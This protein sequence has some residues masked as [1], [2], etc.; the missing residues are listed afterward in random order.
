MHAAL[1]AFSVASIG[2]RRR[3]IWFPDLPGCRGWALTWDDIGPEGTG[4]RLRMVGIGTRSG[5][6]DPR[7]ENDGAGRSM[8]ARSR[9]GVIFLN[10]LGIV[11]GVADVARILEITP[12]RVQAL[13][14]HRG[15]GRMVGNSL[16]FTAA[17]VDN[18][19]VRRTGRPPAKEHK[20]ALAAD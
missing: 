12:R 9:R 13:A 16:A 1:Y 17:D 7:T 19:R 8:A 5:T 3:S 15:L 14:K 4:C 2:I 20:H 6:R 11:L 18:M 10:G